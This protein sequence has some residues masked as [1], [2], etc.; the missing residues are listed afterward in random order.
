MNVVMSDLDY[1]FADVPLYQAL[2]ADVRQG[3][4]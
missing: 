3:R 1:A 4:V 2:A